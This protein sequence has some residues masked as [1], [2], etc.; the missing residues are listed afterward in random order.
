VVSVGDDIGARVMDLTRDLAGEPR[1]ARGVLTVDDHEVN[2]PL[3]L[4]R[5]NERRDGLTAWLPDDIADEENSHRPRAMTISNGAAVVR[6]RSAV[7]GSG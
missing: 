1:A 3:A 2:V 4:H 7:R 6:A 5:R